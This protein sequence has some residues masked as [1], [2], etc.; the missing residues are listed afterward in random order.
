[1][2]SIW[3]QDEA[4]GPTIIYYNQNHYMYGYWKNN[5]PSGINVIKIDN[6]LFYVN[7]RNGKIV[8]NLLAI[9]EKYNLAVVVTVID[10]GT[11]S[12]F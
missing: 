12:E 7:Y 11:S 4:T 9:F 10:R 5:I 6:S 3:N 8:G 2:G 1:M